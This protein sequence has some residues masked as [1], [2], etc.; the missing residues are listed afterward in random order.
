MRSILPLTAVLLVAATVSVAFADFPCGPILYHSSNELHRVDDPTNIAG[1]DFGI[2][3]IAAASSK[4]TDNDFGAGTA[5]LF[6]VS[7]ASLGSFW[8]IDPTNAT[9]TLK[10]TSFA[11]LDIDSYVDA[12]ASFDTGKF[13][14]LSVGGEFYDWTRDG[15]SLRGTAAGTYHDADSEMASGGV[16]AFDLARNVWDE[17]CKVFATIKNS[18]RPDVGWLMSVDPTNAKVGFLAM[19][20]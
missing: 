5:S 10:V 9:A 14:G 17:D 19:L 2:G 4:L 15:L 20:P 16:F 12:L 8:E 18:G 6:G 7:F 13:F 11:G 1:S 3:T